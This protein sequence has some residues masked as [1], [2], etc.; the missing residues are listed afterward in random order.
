MAIDNRMLAFNEHL[1]EQ[2]VKN[3]RIM[4]LNFRSQYS[5]PSARTLTGKMLDRLGIQTMTHL[6]ANE[7]DWFVPIYQEQI[8]RM[9]PEYLIVASAYPNQ[10]A[11]HLEE[12][13][14]MSELT[15]FKTHRTTYIDDAV[16][17]SPTQYVILAYFD[18]YHAITKAHCP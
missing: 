13:E 4:Y 12:D 17:Q 7:Q 16:Q 18:L 6:T 15:A 14:V 2:G 5:L 10:M 8:K 9:D 1:N 11:E 3:P